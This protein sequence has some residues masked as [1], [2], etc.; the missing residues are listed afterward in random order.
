M[1]TRWP[2]TG[3]WFGVPSGVRDEGFMV[4]PSDEIQIPAELASVSTTLPNDQKVR[5]PKLV[6]GA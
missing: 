5:Q 2:H 3:Q 6:H 1:R 4:L